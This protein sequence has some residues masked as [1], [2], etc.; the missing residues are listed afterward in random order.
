MPIYINRTNA[1]TNAGGVVGSNPLGAFDFFQH[2]FCLYL[3]DRHIR[4][5]LSDDEQYQGLVINIILSL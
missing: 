5:D 1:R 3:L 2:L 4:V